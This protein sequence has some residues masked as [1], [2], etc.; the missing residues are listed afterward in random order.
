MGLCLGLGL[1][2]G[3]CLGLG[4]GLGYKFIFRIL[5]LRSIYSNYTV[6]NNSNELEATLLNVV[7]NKILS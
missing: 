5:K 3:L 4:L 1:G 7:K 6:L 2:L